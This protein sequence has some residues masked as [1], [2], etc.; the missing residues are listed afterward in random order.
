[1]NASQSAS[2][3][4]T[5]KTAA[6]K[7]PARGG[8]ASKAAAGCG[9]EYRSGPI[10]GTAL[11]DGATFRAKGVQYA[12]VNGMAVVEGDIVIGTVKEV[13]EAAAEGG[14]AVLFRSVG[15]T[16]Q[17]FRWPNAVVPFEIDPALPDVDRVFDAL[18][19]WR[20]RTR[21]QFESRTD[22]NEALFPDFV[23]FVPGDGCSSSVGR[24][25][26][27]QQITL[28]D[29]CSAGNAIHEIGHTVGL[30][31]EQSREDRDRF[32]TI[33]FGNID[34][35]QQHNFL[36]QISDGDDIG[37]YDYGSIMHYSPGAFAIDPNQPTIVAKQPLPPGV[38]MGQRTALSQGDLAG[39]QTLYP[40][41]PSTA[42]ELAKD[43]ESD[44]TLKEQAKDPVNDAP[45]KPP[46]PL[47]LQSPAGGSPFVL[48]TPHQAPALTGSPDGLAEQV[49]RLTQ[50]VGSLQQDLAA[51]SASHHS[52]LT[53]LGPLLAGRDGTGQ[54][55]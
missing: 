26:G 34:P 9:G 42:K 44:F 7:P 50:L 14:N 17:Q 20:S 53:R 37:P 33:V 51:V 27:M 6:A 38:V 24:Q 28:G 10:C 15:I 19:H 36:Q 39:V 35:A 54:L 11:L 22:D 45:P 21:I 30:W 31:H 2:P 46:P 55:S 29:D 3:R 4:R 13:Q 5:Q 23:R 16:G 1:M 25:G 8:R 47:E 41:A 52:L 12:D 32:V 43:P 49:H 18:A 48:A 40:N